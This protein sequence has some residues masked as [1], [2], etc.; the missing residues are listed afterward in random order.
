V[1]TRACHDNALLF[2]HD[3]APSLF[4]PSPSGAVAP[5]GG[6]ALDLDPAGDTVLD[7]ASDTVLYRP[8]DPFRVPI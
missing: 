8:S 4:P 3:E 5:A 1:T 2:L 6:T 7:P